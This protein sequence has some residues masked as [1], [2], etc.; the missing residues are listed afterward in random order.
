MCVCVCVCERERERE[1]EIY[2][3]S[4]SCVCREVLGLRENSTSY[5]HRESGE[6]DMQLS[7]QEELCKALPVWT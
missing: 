4:T 5:V 6:L 7:A 3:N 1:R 2:C